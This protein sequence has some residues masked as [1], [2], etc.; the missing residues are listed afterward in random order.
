MKEI[1]EKTIDKGAADR[2]K[3][4]SVSIVSVVFVMIIALLAIGTLK[5]AAGPMMEISSGVGEYRSGV[6][7]RLNKEF[8]DEIAM[9][10]RFIN[11][12]GLLQRVMGKRE[13]DNYDIIKDEE[14]YLHRPSYD[15]SRR[16]KKYTKNAVALYEYAEAGG[17]DFLIIETPPT[18]MKGITRMPP[19]VEYYDDRNIDLFLAELNKRGVPYIDVRELFAELGEDELRYRTDH[20]WA[21]P[22]AF[23]T[24]GVTRDYL[25]DRYGY[26]LDPDGV[27]VD[28][29]NY[30]VEEYPD[31]FLGAIGIRVG[32]YYAG[33]DDFE[34][35]IPKFETNLTLSKFLDKHEPN[36]V[37]TGDFREAFINDAYLAPDHM[38]KY[39]AFLRNGY[40][41]SIIE[42]HANEN[43]LK[44]L[45]ITDSF[46]RPYAQYL[47]LLFSETVYLDASR[48]SRYTDNVKEYIESYDPD[49]LICMVSGHSIWH[50]LLGFPGGD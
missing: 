12:F 6:I 1:A 36:G 25:N 16:V 48:D 27:F 2:P 43:G 3:R 32:K 28:S 46:G 44:C 24:F 30:Y 8:E 15:R 4:I 42:N 37:F 17:M 41:E 5:D 18:I 40:V 21:M 39:Q 22:L 35:Y 45:F 31:S 11:S 29:D 7:K 9:K 20:H 33:M 50:G 26:D 19:G 14:G 49:I 38:N 47:S 34:I 23:K 13:V 10:Q